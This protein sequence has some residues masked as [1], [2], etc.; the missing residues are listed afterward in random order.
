M[1]TETLPTRPAETP[2]TPAP[3]TPAVPASA[4]LHEPQAIPASWKP[5]FAE[6]TTYYRHLPEL[7][8]EGEAGRFVVIKGDE[9]CHTWDTCQD[10]LQ[11]GRE[12][13]GD[14][15]FMVHRVDPRDV[16]RLA[17]FFPPREAAC[18]G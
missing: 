8:T 11:Y 7:L 15:L 14:Q 4:P 6:L 12:R 1:S 18:P 5:L 10:A 3:G 13:F 17:R 2:V 16:E 9:L